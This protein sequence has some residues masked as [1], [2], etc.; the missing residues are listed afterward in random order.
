MIA[1]VCASMNLWCRVKL[2]LGEFVPSGKS[3]IDTSR[4][5]PL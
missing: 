4:P 1:L 2:K 5:A 3:I